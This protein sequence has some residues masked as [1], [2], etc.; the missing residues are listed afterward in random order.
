MKRLFL[1]TLISVVA[2]SS[3]KKDEAD[4]DPIPTES[5]LQY[6]PLKTGNYWVYQR[7]V[8]DS[9]WTNCEIKATDTVWVTKDTLIN[10]KTYFKL[11]DVTVT[12][13]HRSIYYRDSLDYIVDNLGNIVVSN[14]DFETKLHEEYIIVNETDTAFYWYNKMQNAPFNIEVPAGNFSC[15]DNK[16]SFFRQ[17]D[18]FETEFNTHQLYA[19]GTGPVFN[20]AMFAHSGGGYKRELV[21][22][23]VLDFK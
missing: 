3:C 6:F 23:G 15:L 13:Q 8:C 10:D 4:P 9:T 21:S 1:L 22:S 19:K 5:V 18:N 12:G 20:Q 17:T 7:S 11:E 2:F 16:M 14:T